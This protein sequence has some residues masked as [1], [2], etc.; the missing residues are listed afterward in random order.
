MTIT[1]DTFDLWV[2][3]HTAMLKNE[4]S[5]LRSDI[6]E[7]RGDIKEI[8]RLQPIAKDEHDR[9]CRAREQVVK[10][11]LNARQEKEDMRWKLTVG[12]AIVVLVVHT[13]VP[14]EVL[15]QLFSAIF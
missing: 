13:F 9:M 3:E 8:R 4:F 10:D 7:L 6:R 5:A 12:G 1:N 11:D 2:R 14:T 15:W